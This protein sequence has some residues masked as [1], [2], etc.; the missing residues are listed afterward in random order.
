M[1]SEWRASN[2]QAGGGRQVAGYD[3]EEGSLLSAVSTKKYCAAVL[4][5][6]CGFVVL[7]AI[8]LRSVMLP[9]GVALVSMSS[10][11]A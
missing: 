3:D 8:L 6:F 1:L 9:F 5:L 11:L 4:L 10:G 2:Q 7:P